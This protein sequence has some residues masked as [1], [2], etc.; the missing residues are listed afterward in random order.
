MRLAIAFLLFCS[1]VFGQMLGLVSPGP[2][3]FHTTTPT[4]IT[5]VNTNLCVA[6]SGTTTSAVDSTGATLAVVGV[7]LQDG[8]TAIVSDSKSNTWTSL[9]QAVNT[10][11]PDVVLFYAKNLVAGASHTFTVAGSHANFCVLTFSGVSTSAPFD[12]QN[13]KVVLGGA[14]TIHPNGT[15]PVTPSA[16]NSLWVTTAAGRNA[17]VANSLGLSFTQAGTVM[18]PFYSNSMAYFV[19]TT[20]ASLDPTWTFSAAADMSA[21]VAVFK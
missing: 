17:I 11:N 5:L 9:T 21:A 3:A 1:S 10:D 7:T 12:V 15:S 4:S 20:A 2:G 14:T 19:Q 18:G 13:T 6:E 8:S 16:N